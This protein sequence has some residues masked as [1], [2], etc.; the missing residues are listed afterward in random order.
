[1]SATAALIGQVIDKAILVMLGDKVSAEKQREIHR[2]ID[3]AIA[4]KITDQEA[5]A[6]IRFK[7]GDAL[8]KLLPP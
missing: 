7:D 1:M 8:D 3:E 4:G 6:A 2:V 5:Y